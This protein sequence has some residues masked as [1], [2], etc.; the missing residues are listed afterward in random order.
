MAGGSVGPR[1]LSPP[2]EQGLQHLH[3]PAAIRDQVRV[4]IQQHPRVVGR[5]QHQRPMPDRIGEA[6]GGKAALFQAQ[7]IAA[8][9]QAEILFR[10]DEAVLGAAQGFQPFA[11]GFAQR[12]VLTAI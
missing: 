5:R 1:T 7:R 12:A 3:R 6:I 8:A 10:D 2:V 9:A 4:A 11:R